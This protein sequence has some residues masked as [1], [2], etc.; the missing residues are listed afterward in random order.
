VIAAKAVML[1][2]RGGYQVWPFC[3]RFAPVTR[4]VAGWFFRHI[5]RHAS[6]SVRHQRTRPPL[7]ADVP[8]EL[9]APR[10]IVSEVATRFDEP[11]RGKRPHREY[12]SWTGQCHYYRVATYRTPAM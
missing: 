6:S 12:D 1:Q 4:P 7:I 5:S 9:A 11:R 10:S 8:A 3:V 2:Q